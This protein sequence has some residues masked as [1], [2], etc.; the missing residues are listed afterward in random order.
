MPLLQPIKFD[1]GAIS[2]NIKDSVS[3]WQA[4]IV[5]YVNEF[6]RRISNL[7]QTNYELGVKFAA[8]GNVKEAIFRF[9]VTLY[10]A[11]KFVQAW[12]NMGCC[13]LAKGDKAKAVQAFKRTLQLK[14]D[15]TDAKF[16]LATIDA[17]LL[18]PQDRPQRMP[19]HMMEGFF[20]RIAANYDMM[21]GQMQYAGPQLLHDTLRAKLGRGDVRVLD[22]GCGTGLSGMP[23]RKE[24]TY[25]LGMDVTPEMAAIARQAKLE[26]VRV[27]D[28]V[29]VQDVNAKHAVMNDAPFDVTF[30][31]NV[32][33]FVGEASA[34][35]TNAARSTKD[36]GIVAITHDPYQGPGGYGILP[37]TGRFGHSVEYLRQLGIAAGL[38]PLEHDVLQIYPQ[39]K[40][41]LLTFTKKAAA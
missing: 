28:D 5:R 37:S 29:L 32:L 41:S 34:F 39:A 40:T 8:A 21:E 14:P 36:G 13:Q 6:Q 27:Y 10:F 3:G 19:H 33:P 31:L 9:K 4:G 17:N 24:A 15:H 35:L 26:G 25:I 1:P 11:P 23:W 38:S 12:Y 7:P 18:Q 22:L 20:A 2:R 30:A 16:M